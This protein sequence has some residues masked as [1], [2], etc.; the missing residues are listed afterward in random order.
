M[1]IFPIGQMVL[2]VHAF[3]GPSWPAQFELRNERLIRSSKFMMGSCWFSHYD[4][5]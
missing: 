5:T 1:K 4:V 2:I 3:V